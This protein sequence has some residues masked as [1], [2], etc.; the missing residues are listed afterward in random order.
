MKICP[1]CKHECTDDKRFCPECGTELVE[2]AAPAAEEPEKKETKPAD[3]D[4]TAEFDAEDVS[5]HKLLA[6]V[7]Y[8]LGPIGLIIALLGG[9][10]SPYTK[11]HIRQSLKFM[12]LGALIGIVG[13]VLSAAMAVI[14]SPLQ[15][16]AEF[17]PAA[18]PYYYI[19]S[20]IITLLTVCVPFVTVA[21]LAVLVV[22]MIITFIAICR[23][24]SIEP[25][26]VRNLKF[27][28]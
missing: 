5:D 9:A 25:P 1:N 16:L 15:A 24:K 2:Q 20:F 7:I 27:L 14:M 18:T 3:F 17:I 4:H 19:V 8:L 12:V 11:F 26:I 13:T 28:K 23:G 22:S 10:E 6:M 21:L